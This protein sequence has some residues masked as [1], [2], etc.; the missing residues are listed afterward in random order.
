MGGSPAPQQ[1]PGIAEAA[2]LSAQTGSDALA[3]MMGRTATTDAWAAEDRARYERTFR[4]LED[5]FVADAAG[6]DTSERRQAEAARAQASV[7]SQ[8]AIGRGITGRAMAAMGVAPGS[9]RYG[10]GA[11]AGQMAET[12]AAVGAGNEARRAVE[13]EGRARTAQ[14]IALGQGAQASAA[15]LMGMGTSAGGAG[16]GMAMNGYGQSGELLNQAYQND[17]AAWDANES[18]LSSLLGGVG[19]L[20]GTVL[21]NP[22]MLS[23]LSDEDA[24][25]DRRPARGA[26]GALKRMP[27]DR[28]RYRPGQGDEAE[29]T[30][31]M[32]QDFRRETGLGDGRTIPVVDAVG[33]TMGAVKELA[34]EV[35]RLARRVGRGAR[36][37]RAA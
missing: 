16:F 25:T 36:P 21:S 14:A 6:Y 22:G 33:V 18:G 3:W 4:P 37:R 1:D 23:I 15:G 30:G 24:K 13:A 32:A 27:V 34:G 5:A 31:V 20:G 10:G 35:E 26:L 7:R 8:A 9:G 17:L 28:W 11:A 12:L 29:H 19:M 2:K